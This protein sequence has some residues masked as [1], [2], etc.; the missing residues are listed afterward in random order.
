MASHKVTIHLRP[1]AK[2]RPRFS[3]RG[4]A[5]TPQAAHDYEA[6]IREAWRDSNGPTFDGP[7]SVSVTFRKNRLTLFVKEMDDKTKSALTG[8]VDNYLKALLDGLQ[9]EDGAFLNDRQVH[10]V[11]ARKA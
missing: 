10:H 9:G 7:V 4:R 8:D 5:Y 11:A 3:K 6:A 1:K 2:P